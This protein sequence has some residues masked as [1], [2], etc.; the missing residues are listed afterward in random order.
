MTKTIKA[1]E[2]VYRG[3][4]F[5]SRLEAR[6]A[7]FFDAM[8]IAWDYEK[9]GFELPSGRYLPDFWLPDFGL[10]FEVKGERLD[11]GS[12]ELQKIRELTQLDKPVILSEGSIGEE[13]KRLF[14]FDMCDSGGGESVT[15]CYFIGTNNPIM[16]PSSGKYRWWLAVGDC[17]CASDRMYCDHNYE[18]LECVL[19]CGPAVF[20][21]DE[22]GK[23]VYSGR[24]TKAVAAA[25]S[26]RFEH[27]ETPCQL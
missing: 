21:C 18:P 27:G 23:Q 17:R 4:R 15:G 26:A 7:V 19:V 1:I 13:R 25:R 5:R 22:Q 24:L 8:G 12:H 3:Y 2:T 10:W 9:E 14:A 16:Q 11:N 6:W 20:A